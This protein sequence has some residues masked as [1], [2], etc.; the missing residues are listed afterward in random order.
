MTQQRDRLQAL[1]NLAE[2]P[3]TPEAEAENARRRIAEIL[4][5]NPGCSSGQ[6][7]SWED[8]LRTSMFDFSAA[9]AREVEYEIIGRNRRGRVSGSWI[10]EAWH[11]WK[12]YRRQGPLG[13]VARFEVVRLVNGEVVIQWPCPVCG[14]QAAY[15]LPSSLMSYAETEPAARE[16]IMSEVF[17]RLNGDSDNRCAR[18]TRNSGVEGGGR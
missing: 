3:A 17:T 9:M 1:R 2:H 11:E 6:P 8:L 14:A 10:P 18:C 4:E 7:N 5:K 12:V 13:T 16:R 15:R